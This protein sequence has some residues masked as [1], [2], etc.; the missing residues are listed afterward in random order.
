MSRWQRLTIRQALVAVLALAAAQ[1]T[2]AD[3]EPALVRAPLPDGYRE[4]CGAC[5]L[6]YPPS[7]L[8]AASWQRIMQDLEHHFG[9][10]ASLDPAATER[11]SAWLATASSAARA[12]LPSPPDDRITRSRWFLDEHDEL[13][14][15]V[16]ERESIGSPANCAAC[17]I[18]ADQGDFDEHRIPR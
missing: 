4:E 18:R 11:L 1:S 14:P 7:L 8:P 3:D 17:H 15:A 16:F 2:P 5:H 12:R 6:P 9:T 10:D 13:S